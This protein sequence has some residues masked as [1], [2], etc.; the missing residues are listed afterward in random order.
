MLQHNFTG[1]TAQEFLL[2]LCPSSL[3]SLKPFTST[4][5]VLLNEQGGIIDDTIITKHSDSAFYVVTNAG[6]SVEDKAHI[7]QKLEEWNAAHKGREVKWETLEGWGLLALQ[8]PKAKDVLQRVT[9]QDLNKVKFGS[10]VFADIKTMDGQTVK[11]HVARGGYTGE[12]GFEVSIPPEHTLALS[13]TIASHPD[14]MLIGLGARDSLRLEAGM[15]LYGHDLDESV[16]PVEGGLSWVIGKDR[17]APDAQPSFPG[18]SRILEELANG[19]SRRRVG[20]EVI[21]SPAREGCKVL[22]A[23]GEKEIGVITSGIPSPTLGTNI[24]MGYIANGSHKKGTAVKVEVRKKLRD[25]FVKPMPFVPTK[26]F[27]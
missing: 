24:A 12:D 23:L 25:A 19:P 1:P 18:K 27:K 4:L 16:S 2:T 26:Y 17:R 21:G 22:D 8:G 7:S 11:C 15:C 10:S 9:D 5:S 6:R 13:N 3:D 14:V 20:F